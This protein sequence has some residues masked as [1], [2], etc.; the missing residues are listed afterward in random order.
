MPDVKVAVVRVKMKDT[1][2]GTQDITVSGFGTPKAAM[3]VCS[4]NSALQTNQTGRK[5]SWG[6]TDG[7]ADR[8]AYASSEDGV[9]PSDTYR[10][11]RS[12]V[13][14]YFADDA[15]AGDREA[16]FQ[17]W[18][19]D[20]VR[21]NWTFAAGSTPRGDNWMDVVLFGGADLSAKVDDFSVPDSTGSVGVTVG[22]EADHV[23]CLSTGLAFGT[24]L[25]ATAG[26]ALFCAGACANGGGAD[27][28]PQFGIAQI[29]KDA[30]SPTEQAAWFDNAHVV[31][32][33]TPTAGG[34]GVR[35]GSFTSTAF[36]ATR[37][38]SDGADVQVA[39][40]ALAYG[41]ALTGHTVH[42]HLV[43]TATGVLDDT[44][45]G[46]KPQ[47]VLMFNTNIT[48]ANQIITA[49]T[50]GAFAW[51][52]AV[53]RGTPT[54][55]SIAYFGHDAQTTS[56]TGDRVEGQLMHCRQAS[57]AAAYVGA[58]NGWLDGGFSVN[59]STV[60]TGQRR[61]AA[62]VIGELL[63]EGPGS[64]TAPYL[65]ASG[66]GA[67]TVEGPGS[68][69]A[70]YLSADGAGDLTVEGSGQATAPFLSADGDGTVQ[71]LEGGHDS[72]LRLRTIL[73]HELMKISRPDWVEDDLFRMD[74]G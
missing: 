36:T 23:V 38:D 60:P 1:G 32:R 49:A 74:G 46:F 67:L 20:G 55:L 39:Y 31:R 51:G 40:L 35:L 45:A 10:Q 18:I 5:A 52:C 22:F 34:A 50:A 44:S 17:E 16:A 3:F 41:G 14:V 53:G 4:D 62:I 12:N 15:G 71:V 33:I 25:N 65:D 13:V 57:G 68:A 37:D 29:D 26:D 48:G 6:F 8:C 21:I 19:T 2:S 63:F 73:A 7:S 28:Q 64:A 69:T 30:A 66:S 24:S 27:P 70:P 54:E 72:M 43:P 9:N 61:C 58:W 11:A 59:Y 42:Q 47:A 56:S